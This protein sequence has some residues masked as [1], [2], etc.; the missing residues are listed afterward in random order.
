MPALPQ[1]N[2]KIV[3]RI[4]GGINIA[5]MLAC[6]ASAAARDRGTAVA[7]RHNRE[8]APGTRASSS[9]I[10]FAL[11]PRLGGDDRLTWAQRVQQHQ[12][13]ERQEQQQQ[14]QAASQP[15]DKKVR[16]AWPAT[17]RT[18]RQPSATT[19]VCSK[20]RRQEDFYYGAGTAMFD[21]WTSFLY[22]GASWMTGPHHDQCIAFLCLQEPSCVACDGKLLWA[23][24][25]L[26]RR[27]AYSG[28]GS[29]HL[30]DLSMITLVA[31]CHSC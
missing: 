18:G 6:P 19:R 1:D 12:Q 26:L 17:L 31:I 2:I 16:E 23:A 5:K 15:Q 25:A 4:R 20:H 21:G 9:R 30:Q 13:Q 14:Q 24:S 10:R 8:D 3:I 22:L 11:S 7:C 29:N 27:L 28:S